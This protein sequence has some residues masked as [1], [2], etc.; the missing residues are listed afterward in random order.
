MKPCRDC[1]YELAANARGCP[2][3][4]RNAEA[5]QMLERIIWIGLLLILL[6]GAG[7][8]FLLRR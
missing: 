5:E 1:G 3:C 6:A 2:R 4:A 8:I 7:A